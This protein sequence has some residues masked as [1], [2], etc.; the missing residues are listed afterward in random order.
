MR[1]WD[2]LLGRKRRTIHKQ[3]D[4]KRTAAAAQLC[5]ERERE[6]DAVAGRRGRQ[7]SSPLAR[8]I[9]FSSERK[10]LFFF[11][12]LSSSFH[13]LSLFLLRVLDMLI[14]ST[15]KQ[16]WEPVPK[17]KEKQKLL[18]LCGLTIVWPIRHLYR[19]NMST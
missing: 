4:K 9:S 14:C 17:K 16:F 8:L 10:S 6:V 19:T 18:R 15:Q 1:T 3:K 11:F 2:D 13:I 5:G 12:F 7:H